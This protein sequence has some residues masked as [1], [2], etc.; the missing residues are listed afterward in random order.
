MQQRKGRP[1]IDI[2]DLQ[3]E[4][5][6]EEDIRPKKGSLSYSGGGAPS[7]RG[8]SQKIDNGG[9]MAQALIAAIAAVAIS[10]FVSFNMF[11]PKTDIQAMTDKVNQAATQAQSSATQAVSGIQSQVSNI[12]VNYATKADLVNYAT[13]AEIAGLKAPDLSTYP[14]KAETYTKAE[15][16]A[17]LLKKA[18]LGSVSP[19]TTT[20]TGTTTTTGTG[21]T[22]TM[23][24]TQV[25]SMSTDTGNKDVTLTVVNNS[26]AGGNPT[27]LI[28]LL[29]LSPSAYDTAKITA[30][31]AYSTLSGFTAVT[32]GT[33]QNMSDVPTLVQKLFWIAPSYYMDSG[34]SKTIWMHFDVKTTDVVTWNLTVQ[35]LN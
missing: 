21:Y 26:G 34:S 10:V 11:V 3:P 8:R 15:I 4:E 12:I 18:N 6:P 27:L 35:V 9:N 23:D 14:T 30:Y 31:N 20:P 7:R 16:D 17:L 1:P 25:I 2:E 5:E 29:P 22:V 28:S 13:K 33:K 32:A 19:G 24:K